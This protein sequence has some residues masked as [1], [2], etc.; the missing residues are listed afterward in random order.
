M[1]IHAGEWAGPHSIRG[2]LRCGAA[3]IGHGTRAIEDHD[4]VAL[5]AREGIV[6]EVCPSSNVSTEVFE[7]LEDVPVR[8]LLDA[9]VRVTISSDDAAA[10]GTD[11]AREYWI[12]ENAIDAAFLDAGGKTALRNRY[13][14][15]AG[16]T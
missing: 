3:R 2:A 7:K 14:T 5:L 16:R 11:I 10:F 8:P 6:L 1:S 9:G 4:L 15:A 12:A 13:R